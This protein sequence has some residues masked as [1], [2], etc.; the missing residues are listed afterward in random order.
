MVNPSPNGAPSEFPSTRWSKVVAAA[1]LATPEARSALAELCS[2]YWYPIY[3]FIR[4]KGNDAEKSQDL[5]QSYFARL[6]EKPVLAAADPRK[7]R[8]RS[9]I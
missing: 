5:A 7:G 6:L 2:A 3:V 1:D 9:F 8:F 4:R